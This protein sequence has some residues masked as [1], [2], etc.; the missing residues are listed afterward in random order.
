MRPQRLLRH[1]SAGAQERCGAVVAQAATVAAAASAVEPA[2]AQTPA[3]S[4]G[5]EV[6]APTP[7]ACPAPPPAFVIG[8]GVMPAPLLAAVLDRATIREIR[9]PGDAAPEP[10]YRPS[11]SLAEFVRCRDLTCRWPGCDHPAD[12]CDLDHTMP[13]RPVPPMPQI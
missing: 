2:P 12:R 11:T 9:H 10:G 6:S 8:G 7:A 13:I 3:A 5:P 1:H 4:P